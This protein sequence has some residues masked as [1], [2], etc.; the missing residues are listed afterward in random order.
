MYYYWK[1]IAVEIALLFV[2]GFRHYVLGDGL[3][4]TENKDNSDT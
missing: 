2:N 1:G 3:E 4:P